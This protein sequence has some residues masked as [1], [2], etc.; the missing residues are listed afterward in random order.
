MRTTLR[1][2]KVYL[3]EILTYK[4]TEEYRDFTQYYVSRLC[5][6]VGDEV[7]GIKPIT[8]VCLIAGYAANS[9]RAV[10]EVKEIT[11]DQYVDDNDNL[12][13]DYYFTIFLGKVLETNFL[14]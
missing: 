8:E 9:P 1:I 6:K 10:V 2:K 4:K 14:D 12:I 13:D 7:T 5:E 11:V 3:D